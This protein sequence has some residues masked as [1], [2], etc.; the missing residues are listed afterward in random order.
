M[1]EKSYR[2]RTDVGRDKVVKA[3]LTQDIKFLEILS[4]KINQED[5][6]KLH[7]SNYGIIVGRVLGNEA[8]GIPNARVSVFI[9][10]SDEDKEKTDIVNLYPYHTILTKDKENRRYNLLPDESNN[11]CHRIVGTFPNKRLILDNETEIEIYEK[12]WKY[13]TVTNQSGDYMIFGVPTGNHTIHVDIDLSDIGI[14]SQKPRDFFYKG[15]N[16]E[17]F[18]SAEQFKEG[19]DLDNLT[20]LL[21]QNTATYVYPFFGDTDLNDIAITRCDISIPYKF[22]PTCVFFGS[23]I[24]DKSGQ[25]IG[26]GCGPTRWMGYN[27]NLVTGEGTIEMIRKTPDGLVE[28]FPIKGNRLIDGD[29]VWCYQIPMNLDYIGTD[30]FGNIIPVEDSTKGI[31]T[32]T[33]VRFRIS[34]LETVTQ[35]SPQ[36]VAKY[37]VPN[38]HEL[39]AQSN[40]PQILQG[41]N[42][43]KC[44]EFGSATP[45]EYFRDLLWNKVYSVKN[46]I[47]RFEHKN[48]LERIFSTGE[49]GYSGIRSITDKEENNRFPFNNARFHLRFSYR[50]LCLLMTML[51]ILL[52]FYN[53]L[54]SEII[55]WELGI[56]FKI[57]GKRVKLNFGRPLQWLSSFIKCVGIEGSSFFEELSDRIYVPSCDKNCGSI[58]DSKG[59]KI[60]KD[61]KELLDRI[62]QTLALEY[63][64]VNLDF[65]N[66]WINGALY[67]P[68]WFWK[69]KAKK[70]YF[71]GLIPVSA[72]NTF[73]SCEKQVSRFSLAQPCSTTYD[74][75][76]MPHVSQS[77]KNDMHYDF[78]KQNLRF[79]V[80]KEFTN[81]DNLKVYYYAP[82]IPND[83]NYRQNTSFTNYNQLFATDIILLG[84]LNSC[85]LDNLP[86]TFDS[87]P[88][89]TVNIPFIATL[90]GEESGDG[91][92]TGL[93]WGYEGYTANGLL[94][95]LDCTNVHTRYKSCVN[96]S[97]LSELYVTFDMDIT[98]DDDNDITIQHDGVIT[99]DEIVENET[100]AKFASL[101][102][103]GLTNLIKNPTTNYNTYK[104]H[105][106]YPVNF[107]GHLRNVST[108]LDGGESK[109]IIDNRDSNYVMYRL[110]EGKD[111][112]QYGRHKKHFYQGIDSRFQFPLYNNSFYFY[113]GLKEGKTAIDKFNSMFNAS[114]A[115][116]NKYGFT[117][118][119]V[120]KPGKWCYDKKN[121]RT[122]FGT[123]DIEFGGLTDTFSY[124]LYNEFNELLLS[125][126]DVQSPD[127]RFGYRVK[128][129]GGGYEITNDGYVKDGTLRYLKN[130]LPV[131]N[132][133]NE[134]VF[135]ENGVYYLEVI[136]SFGMKV[137]QRINMV[138]NTL[139][140]NIE[141]VKLGTKFNSNTQRQDICGDKNYFGEIRIKSFV[142]D[143]EEVF[144]TSLQK[145]FDDGDEVNEPNEVT[146]KVTCTDGSEVYLRLVSESIKDT[147]IS[148]F[149]C[150]GEG[151]I[152][153]VNLEI[154]GDGIYTL[155]FN[156]WKPGDYKLIS[157]QIC[158]NVL[159]DNISTDIINIENGEKFQAFLN[160]I[161]LNIIYGDNFKTNE[162]VNESFPKAWLQLENPTNYNFYPTLAQNAMEWDMFLDIEVIKNID[163]NGNSY[164]YISSLSKL[165]VLQ[166]Q[167]KTIA[168]MRDMAYIYSENEAPQIIITTRGGKE[169]IL[170]RN[171]HPNYTVLDEDTSVC[172]EI[173]IEN[174]NV[175]EAP[176]THPHIIDKF[177]GGIVDA[178]NA[179]YLNDI[180]YPTLVENNDLGNY[181]AMFTNNGGMVSLQ[182]GTIEA[183]IV[184]YYEATPSDA[185]PLMGY[186][187]TKIITSQVYPS[188][189]KN[190]YFRSLFVD[191]KINITGGLW[192]PVYCQYDVYGYKNSEW[193]K[194]RFD[195]N[196][197]NIAPM[198]YDENY[199]IIGDDLSYS[200]RKKG[201]NKKIELTKTISQIDERTSAFTMSGSFHE[202]NIDNLSVVAESEEQAISLLAVKFLNIFN[203]V[204]TDIEI[205]AT[206]KGTWVVNYY[207]LDNVNTIESLNENVDVK[208]VSHLM[209]NDN[210]GNINA[211]KKQDNLRL[212]KCIL[213][214]DDNEYDVRSEFYHVLY[215]SEKDVNGDN[216]PLISQAYTR[217]NNGL[218]I[219]YGEFISLNVANVKM[220]G[221]LGVDVVY[222]EITSESNCI[223]N[224]YI[225]GS[226]EENFKYDVSDRVDIK[227]CALHYGISDSNEYFIYEDQK[228]YI[229]GKNLEKYYIFV[230]DVNAL[231]EYL[232][233]PIGDAPLPTYEMEKNG[234]II[235]GNITISSL[236]D[237]NGYPEI[238]FGGEKGYFRI[239]RMALQGDIINNVDEKYSMQEALSKYGIAYDS[240]MIDEKLFYEINHGG[241]I[242]RNSIHYSH[243]VLNKGGFK[244]VNNAKVP[245]YFYTPIALNG[246]NLYFILTSDELE[247]L[248]SSNGRLSEKN[249]YFVPKHEEEEEII[250][251]P[252]LITLHFNSNEVS[253]YTYNVVQ[254]YQ[255]STEKTNKY[256]DEEY[257]VVYYYAPLTSEYSSECMLSYSK[258]DDGNKIDI[259]GQTYVIE[260]NGINEKWYYRKIDEYDYQQ[261]QNIYIKYKGS[262]KVENESYYYSGDKLKGVEIDGTKITII[263]NAQ[264]YDG[265]NILTINEQQTIEKNDNNI[266]FFEKINRQ[267]LIKQNNAVKCWIDLPYKYEID[268]ASNRICII[269]NRTNKKSYYQIYHTLWNKFV[270]NDV[271]DFSCSIIKDG[272][273]DDES[274]EIEANAP[275]LSCG[276]IKKYGLP[277]NKRTITSFEG[278]KEWIKGNELANVKI[279]NDSVVNG[280]SLQFCV[281][282]NY[283]LFNNQYYKVEKFQPKHDE[284][285]AL[286]FDDNEIKQTNKLYYQSLVIKENG[287]VAQ[288]K[289]FQIL[290]DKWFYAIIL[291]HISNGIFYFMEDNKFYAFAPGIYSLKNGKVY[292]IKNDGNFNIGNETNI[293]YDILQERAKQLYEA[294]NWV[295][296]DNEVIENEKL[297]TEGELQIYGYRSILCKINDIDVN[298][299][300]VESIG[301]EY[302]YQG[303]MFTK[304]IIEENKG[305][306]LKYISNTNTYRICPNLFNVNEKWGKY[307][308]EN[309][310]I[311]HRLKTPI[312]GETYPYI[313][314]YCDSEI[315]DGMVNLKSDNGYFFGK[316]SLGMGYGDYDQ[317]PLNHF[318]IK[319]CYNFMDENGQKTSY[320]STDMKT[321][322]RLGIGIL[323]S[324]LYAKDESQKILLLENDPYYE[325]IL[326]VFQP[327]TRNEIMEGTEL[328]T[329]NYVKKYNNVNVFTQTPISHV[330]PIYIGNV[331]EYKTS[332][333]QEKICLPLYLIE[334]GNQDIKQNVNTLKVYFNGVE[335]NIIKNTNNPNIIVR[336]DFIQV[337][338][339]IDCQDN[340]KIGYCK[341]STNLL[342]KISNGYCFKLSGENDLNEKYFI[343]LRN[344]NI[345]YAV[346]KNKKQTKLGIFY[347][348]STNNNGNNEKE[349]KITIT[350]RYGSMRDDGVNDSTS[351]KFTGTTSSK[352]DFIIY[353]K[354]VN[355]FQ[356]E[357]NPDD[358]INDAFI[359]IKECSDVLHYNF[360]NI[361]TKGD[362]LVDYE[363]DTGYIDLSGL[364]S[365]FT[366]IYHVYDGKVICD[367]QQYDI[368]ENESGKYVLVDICKLNYLI[369]SI[370]T[371]E[372]VIFDELY[373][374]K[375]NKLIFKNGIEYTS[376]NYDKFPIT[377][378]KVDWELEMYFKYKN[379]DKE[380]I[381]LSN[382]KVIELID[383]YCYVD[384]ISNDELNTY[385][386][387]D[388][389]KKDEKTYVQYKDSYFEVQKSN[390]NNQEFITV[391]GENYIFHSHVRLSPIMWQAMAQQLTRN[392]RIEVKNYNV[393]FEGGKIYEPFSNIWKNYYLSKNEYGEYTVNDGSIS[394]FH[395]DALL[396]L[397]E[398]WKSKS[399][400]SIDFF[401]Q[402]VQFMY[403][404]YCEKNNFP[405]ETI[406]KSNINEKYKEMNI[407][408]NNSYVDKNYL[409]TFKVNRLFTYAF[410]NNLKQLIFADEGNKRIMYNGKR[411][412]IRKTTD[413]E[414]YFED[415]N[416]S[417][418][419]LFDYVI[420]ENFAYEKDNNDSNGYKIR[421]YDYYDNSK[422]TILYDNV[423]IEELLVNVVIR[424]KSNGEYKIVSRGN[425]SNPIK[426]EIKNKLTEGNEVIIYDERISQML[427]KVEKIE[428]EQNRI[429]FNNPFANDSLLV[430]QTI[431]KFSNF[432]GSGYNREGFYY[433]ITNYNINDIMVGDI[434]E[435]DYGII[436]LLPQKIISIECNDGYKF[437]GG[438]AEEVIVFNT[439]GVKNK[440]S[441][442]VLRDNGVLG[443]KLYHLE[444][445]D[446]V[447]YEFIS[448]IKDIKEINFDYVIDIPNE[449]KLYKNCLM[450][451]VN[452]I[453]HKIYFDA[454][455]NKE[456]KPL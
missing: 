86:K 398:A 69:K 15:Y 248:K 122:D 321:E 171:I 148:D 67:M 229:N 189:I 259:S 442:G 406:N 104:F 195:V 134:N 404:D 215:G 295:E 36:H 335:K 432:I 278:Y 266:D 53:K 11:D 348:Q 17:Q 356:G 410:F 207:D 38:V 149:G 390:I 425:T 169:P 409:I 222:D 386:Y 196:I 27:R 182:D 175:V 381:T 245:D 333:K 64:V 270:I 59:L 4:L 212:Y 447:Y 177:Y 332:D 170:I 308:Y 111:S 194:G 159:N 12:Y 146:C 312:I 81:R 453:C 1:A 405:K 299:L 252:S 137:I 282:Q 61:K 379:G 420:I 214:V 168:Q 100:R 417:I 112:Q 105:Y 40:Y 322:E 160:D 52:A 355:T 298:V 440:S 216:A 140:P 87:L 103:N 301:D 255:I 256:G 119:Y 334:D 357:I 271:E 56:S 147:K 269:D 414:Y 251:V 375:D 329:C 73:C 331:S 377:Y 449:F 144:I 403:D 179:I 57:F 198:I 326:Y 41:M 445:I 153:T 8:F 291:Y 85:D 99:K 392:H 219:E 125:E 210:I 98:S 136:N 273:C 366:E 275:F 272:F 395:K 354:M 167:M 419:Y 320:I 288:E 114:C 244:N 368:I 76:F 274:V 237:N 364:D 37:L 294:I 203:D 152:D 402:I 280:D 107:D 233:K 347:W 199:N 49:K 418:H 448:Q 437:I 234:I 7:V 441:Y 416:G 283:A 47:P 166:L 172:D 424:E 285:N 150:Y 230:K 71:F 407:S 260:E 286:I 341:D 311:K 435:V 336:G 118:D 200:I 337:Y 363:G 127:L 32:R 192:A 101:N 279:I 367:N 315:I 353:N 389:I 88:S 408:T 143:G 221:E 129:S 178:K 257:Y 154:L 94:M 394:R 174:N 344:G 385:A 262:N 411:Y 44:Y 293:S 208:L 455:N 238:D 346:G 276:I 258:F 313:N 220:K 263:N 124:S 181:M 90:K 387:V 35:T 446:G 65:Y 206:N 45:N 158:D 22:E 380:Y 116:R 185:N 383:G 254:K 319:D 451:E 193:K 106:I 115:N 117:I 429:Y 5:T 309:I 131:K 55:C 151:G 227:T 362:S 300:N 3:S 370:T 165:N 384:Y 281:S 187:T 241:K 155:I 39:Y 58:I 141:E 342:T 352:S 79:G 323:Q 202:V 157:N 330:A 163:D 21:T 29:G 223:F 340:D 121:V 145:Y 60:V 265:N 213:N 78:D 423:N 180:T 310:D 360:S 13:T 110:G 184:D 191:K 427:V 452:G 264:E 108:I 20:Q 9:K 109:T 31:P 92:V 95:D 240:I 397:E 292:F 373:F 218:P 75:N 62:Q 284:N 303:N 211:H 16:K 70:S 80:I 296:V 224:S 290:G 253:S 77:A 261:F 250:N 287:T 369:T 246:D 434:I 277:T 324:N 450:L 438:I 82:G 28:E 328:L 307:D 382:G 113:F 42:Y 10:L 306:S 243:F 54:I 225:E 239:K 430:Y 204:I 316:G 156:I 72:K 23:I 433:D 139:I 24:S 393:T 231:R 345:E 18:D 126:T 209:W 84:S 68:L 359:H 431:S 358:V 372:I 190:K 247:L 415:K 63:E 176:V 74:S 34:M 365:G 289:N 325:D 436:A 135:L 33:S 43:D 412:V 249:G 89:T 400:K 339:D 83:I 374:V 422:K 96:L 66:D 14:L 343:D 48:W 454:K 161:P 426:N 188:D 201:T 388:V 226:K 267:P 30:E 327:N 217:N 19:T 391:E 120:S 318:L 102:H 443:Q 338:D 138:Q 297:G 197:Y 350:C 456:L 25:Y 26:H 173:V 123:I 228:I 50:V 205:A 413:G 97:R 444:K 46:Y 376:N 304:N 6:Y 421:L 2:I 51:V 401:I 142:I 132:I 242:I 268:T 183:N 186:S 130:G 396:A 439:N 93:D 162:N 317:L 399:M 91:V 305:G 314:R 371:N 133:F 232:Q 235:S 236:D 351:T 378:F 128:A 428:K 349:E 361:N 164:D 302:F